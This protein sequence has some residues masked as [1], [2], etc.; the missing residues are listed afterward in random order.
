LVKYYY[1]NIIKEDVTGTAY[2]NM[3][4]LRNAYIILVGKTEGKMFRRAN[5]NI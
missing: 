1:G 4:V 2:S 3:N 5:D